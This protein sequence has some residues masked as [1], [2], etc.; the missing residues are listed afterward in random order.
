MIDSSIYLQVDATVI[1]GLLILLTIG[2]SFKFKKMHTEVIQ[3]IWKWEIK[4]TLYESVLTMILP[5]TVSAMMIIA[6][7]L[8]S[9]PYPFLH[10]I[11]VALYTGITGLG[12]AYVLWIVS[13]LAKHEEKISEDK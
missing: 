5:F 10:G 8:T 7:E 9:T 12:F 4:H 2:S 13:V 11:L 1:A 3:K 6:D